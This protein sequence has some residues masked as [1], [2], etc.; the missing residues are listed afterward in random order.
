MEI[1]LFT[2]PNLI[3]LSN[4]LCGALATLAALYFGE[5]TWALGL[6]LLAA[7]F[8]FFDGMVA[9]LLGQEG[10]LGVQLDSLADDISFGLAP[11]SLLYLW[12]IHSP[13]WVL[14]GGEY[15]GVAVFL[16]A[17]AAALRL[18]KFNIDPTQ[19]EEF[20]GLP[21]PAAAM[22][23][24]SA[25][26]VSLRMGWTVSREGVL[27]LALAAA[28]LMVSPVRMFSLKFAGFGWSENLLRYLFLLFAGATVFGG[29][30]WNGLDGLLAVVP[31]II[32]AYV[33][34]STVR[35]AVSR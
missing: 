26:C 9:R 32:G 25:A 14:A 17:A 28:G 6:I 10:P 22:L 29:L 33:L 27:L 12:Y 4:L 34:V 31:V 24:A 19:H 1:R 35:W 5:P 30:L 2:I 7:L 18:A 8:D 3:T 15:T 16:F 21:S 11:A 13:G 20:C 23:C